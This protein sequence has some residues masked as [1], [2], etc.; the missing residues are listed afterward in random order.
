[1][2]MKIFKY[3][4]SAFTL[5]LAANVMADVPTGY[6][7]SV[8]TATPAEL[9]HSLHLI[10]RGHTRFPYTSDETDTWDILEAADEHPELTTHIIDVY[11]NASYQKETGGNDY[12]NREHSWPKSYGFPDN[13]DMNYPYT[14]AHHLFLSDSGYNTARSNKP[15][16]LCG[17]GCSTYETESNAGRGGSATEVNLTKGEYTEGKWEV[18]SGR[19]GDVARALLYMAVRYEGG[20]HTVTGAMEPDLELTDDE[21]L[22]DASNTGDNEARAYMGYLSTL[23]NWH[24]EDPVDD[25]ERA[26]NDAIYSHQQNRNPF[27]DHPEWVS[28]VFELDCAGSTADTTAPAEVAG[29]SATVQND[30]EVVVNWTGNT[31]EDVFGY[32]VELMLVGADTPMTQEVS[33]K[34]TTTL[35]ITGLSYDSTYVVS[36]YAIDTY[37][38]ESTVTSSVNVTTGAAPGVV[39]GPLW[40]NE[41][42]YD[43]SGSDQNEFVEIA[44]PIATDTAGWTVVLYNGNGGREYATIPLESALGGESNGIGFIALYP[45]SIQNG[46][47]DGIALVNPNGE[48]VQFLSYE[49]HFTAT[50]G[51]AMGIASTDIGVQESGGTTADQSMQLTG[52][53]SSYD[54]FVWN[55]DLTASPGAVNESQTF[56]ASGGDNGGDNGGDD[57]SDDG[58]DDENEEPKEKSSGGSMSWWLLP[59]SLGLFVRKKLN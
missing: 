23:L 54:D 17:D 46:G 56:P 53:G 29:V 38:N 47:P 30:T 7:D 25:V 4:L 40:I 59:L 28:C 48:T 20:T 19:R 57:G 45:S 55:A 35:T 16:A 34:D 27:I 3:S 44:G 5:G 12:Y 51:P 8:N 49:G 15:F 14:D 43:N 32:R 21:A 10:I 24:I 9:K 2:T 39:D 33:G 50:D 52:E 31:E 18:W 36:V 41:I 37:F 22:I 26:R 6:Y 42:H 1:M 11:K 13:G 58:S